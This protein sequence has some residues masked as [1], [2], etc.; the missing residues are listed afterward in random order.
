MINVW[1]SEAWE[2]REVVAAINRAPYTP[3]QITSMG[4]FQWKPQDTDLIAVELISGTQSLLVETSRHGNPTEVIDDKATSVSMQIRAHKQHAKIWADE[5]KGRRQ[6][7]IPELKKSIESVRDDRIMKARRNF[8]LTNEFRYAGAL[9]SKILHPVTGVVLYNFNTIFNLAEP[10]KVFLDLGVSTGGVLMDKLDT[11]KASVFKT[12]GGLIPSGWRAV[13]GRTF[14]SAFL[15]NPEVRDS[16]N[17]FSNKEWARKSHVFAG[18]PWGGIEWEP[19]HNVGS[20]LADFVT[21]DTAILIPVGVPEMFINAGA[22]A[23]WFDALEH[24]AL[25]FY[26]MTT[27]DPKQR[28]MEIDMESHTLPINARPDAIRILDKDAS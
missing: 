6:F 5:I 14:W 25:P 20:P 24:P 10:A 26:A 22:P 8:D 1:D 7:G 28:F 21:D 17:D 11:A 16:W 3:Q 13:A 12:L 18:F 4:L 15:K 27:R 19:Y 9:V 2:Y 23:P